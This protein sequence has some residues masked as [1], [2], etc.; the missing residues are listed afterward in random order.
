MRQVGRVFRD[1]GLGLR[2]EYDISGPELESMCDIVRT[3]PGCLGM[4]TDACMHI[5]PFACCCFVCFQF[6]FFL[7]LTHCLCF[8]T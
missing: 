3:V 8:G 7:S 1:D 6:Q 4:L 5:T 2:D